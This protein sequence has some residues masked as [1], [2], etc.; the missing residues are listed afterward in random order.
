MVL[1]DP[2]TFSVI[3][4]GATYA[5]YR[6]GRWLGTERIVVFFLMPYPVYL[7]AH[8]V[9]EYFRS[10]ALCVETATDKWLFFGAWCL[11]GGLVGSLAALGH[12]KQ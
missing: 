10:C 8:G 3:F 12:P 1:Q 9:V 11:L 4:F 6:V 7:V 5:G 2:A